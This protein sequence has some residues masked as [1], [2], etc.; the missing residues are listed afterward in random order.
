MRL[1]AVAA[2]AAC[3]APPPPVAPARPHDAVRHYTIWLGGARIGT[4]TETER[5]SARGVAL[6]RDERLRYLRGDAELDVA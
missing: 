5:W 1:L 2:L 3:T 6:R 4:A